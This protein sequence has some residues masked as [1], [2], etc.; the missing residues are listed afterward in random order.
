[1]AVCTYDT[2]GVKAPE[3]LLEYKPLVEEYL[4]RS[5]N[6]LSVFSFVNIFAWQDY[7]QFDFKILHDCLCVFAKN[8]IGSFLYL[9]PLG[10][11]VT[12]DVINECFEIM[13]EA[14]CGSGVT[15]IENVTEEQLALFPQEMFSHY[16][17]GYE[18]CYYRD[19][20]AALCGN[21]FKSKRSSYNQ[22]INNYQFD[23][24]PYEEDMVDECLN[25]YDHW[26]DGAKKKQLDDIYVQMIDENRT[27][28]ETVLKYQRS[29]GLTGRVVSID[30]DIK[31]YT[32][33][34]PVKDNMFCIL[35]E[36]ADRAVKGLPV[37]IFREFCRDAALTQHQLINVMDDFG[38]DNIRKAKQSFNPCVLLPLYVVS[39]K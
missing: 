33:G 12:S 32:F 14:N 8:E 27:V 21:A 23:Y 22:F 9:P 7:F 39:K 4:R 3:K 1:M 10:K 18:Y 37:Y 34:F 11:T 6:A 17:K 38:L 19:D 26:A 28:H 5:S 16:K 35:F 29:L 20:I 25:L 24:A 13:E 36:I 15:R 31:A 30:G 2:G